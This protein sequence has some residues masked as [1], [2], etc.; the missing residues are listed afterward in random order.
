MSTDIF[1][2]LVHGPSSPVMSTDLLQYLVLGPVMSTD[3]LEL[4]C[5]YLVPY[6]SC[7]WMSKDTSLDTWCMTH[8]VL[9]CPPISCTCVCYVWSYPMS[10]YPPKSPDVQQSRGLVLYSQCRETVTVKIPRFWLQI[11]VETVT[12]QLTNKSVVTRFSIIIIS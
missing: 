9:E 8:Q 3:I 5:I 11:H 2:Y 7:L 10:I 1:R 12:V 4:M 6:P